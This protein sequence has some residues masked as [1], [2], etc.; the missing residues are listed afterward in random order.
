[1]S[2][3]NAL[4]GILFFFSSELRILYTVVIRAPI[5]TSN[6]GNNAHETQEKCKNILGA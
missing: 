3:A 5:C 6:L 2:G 1:M 4:F